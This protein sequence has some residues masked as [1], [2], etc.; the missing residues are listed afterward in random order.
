MAAA[1]P[2]LAPRS[3]LPAP[4]RRQSP[5]PSAVTRATT[6]A[7]VQP[8]KRPQAVVALGASAGGLE[9]LGLVLRG[10]REASP[11]P[12]VWAPPLAPTHRS[13][14]V[15]LLQ[16]RTRLRVEPAQSGAPALAGTVYIA[17]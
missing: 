16:R 6:T 15:L 14:A 3:R 17:P 2:P 7:R 4:I 8:P 5:R 1:A 13:Q 12:V 10:L 9:S 11:A